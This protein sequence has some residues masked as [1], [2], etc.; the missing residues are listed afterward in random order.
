MPKGD[1]IR[2]PPGFLCANISDTEVLEKEISLGEYYSRVE[3]DDRSEISS[4]TESF[5]Y[6]SMLFPFKSIPFHL[7]QLPA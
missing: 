3:Y 6:Q 2:Q 4:I 7:A 5:C 1:L